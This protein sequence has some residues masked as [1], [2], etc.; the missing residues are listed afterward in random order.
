MSDKVML[1]V[2]D[3]PLEAETKPITLICHKGDMQIEP[4]DDD[5]RVINPLQTVAIAEAI[6][7]HHWEHI[8]TFPMFVHL[9]KLV[10]KDADLPEDLKSSGMGCKHVVGMI[11]AIMECRLEGKRPYLQMPESFLHPSAQLGL[12]DLFV[13]LSR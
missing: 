5:V 2:N 12:A 1:G 3:E 11:C 13:E 7:D 9:F 4:L 10:F 8:R 6:P